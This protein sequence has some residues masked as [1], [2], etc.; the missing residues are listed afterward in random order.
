M[1]EGADVFEIIGTARAM[2]RL[3]P[4]PGEPA[5]SPKA[6]GYPLGSRDR[7]LMDTRGAGGYAPRLR[8]C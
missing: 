6:W 4:E 7:V 3:E 5:L 2:R 1:S 8:E